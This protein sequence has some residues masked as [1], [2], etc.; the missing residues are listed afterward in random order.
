MSHSL[1][2]FKSLLYIM[3]LCEAFPDPDSDWP[4][5]IPL[6]ALLSSTEPKPSGVPYPSPLFVIPQLEL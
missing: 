5:T 2:S 1:T 6:P 4:L 3:S